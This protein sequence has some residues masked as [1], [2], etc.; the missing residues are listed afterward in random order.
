MAASIWKVVATSVGSTLLVGGVGVYLFL[1][2]PPS[3]SPPPAADAVQKLCNEAKQQG[4]DEQAN[5]CFEEQA[6]QRLK[7][8]YCERM[9]PA[10]EGQPSRA[11]CL[12]KVAVALGDAEACPSTG[13]AQETDKCFRELAKLLEDSALC[14]RMSDRG[15]A[16][17][18]LSDV[19]NRIVDP[20]LC[21]RVLSESTRANCISG[22][23]HRGGEADG[24]ISI[25]DGRWRAACASTAA[26]QGN[27]GICSKLPGQERGECW[28]GTDRAFADLDAA[29][30]G[31]ADCLL[32]LAREDIAA[33]AAINDEQA[34]LRA[35]CFLQAGRH[36]KRAHDSVC[37]QL[38]RADLRDEC[39]DGLGRGIGHGDSCAKIRDRKKRTDCVFAAGKNDPIYCRALGDV[40]EMRRC[41]A[42]SNFDTP[43]GTI[44]QGLEPSRRSDCQRTTGARLATLLSRVR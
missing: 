10:G 21:G 38:P 11:T 20:D 37:E 19:A 12:R 5:R 25:V 34:S 3:S 27:P 8:A 16:G 14:A 28:N 23:A 1:H 6:F 33:C 4:G 32:V 43:D 30:G 15:L 40:S 36:G 31:S 7:P 17:D 44:C 18:C 2:G 26:L 22:V 41:I 35:Q 13:S 29:C 24:C 9:A 42:D 39:L